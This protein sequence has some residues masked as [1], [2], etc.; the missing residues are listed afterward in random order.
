MAV[1]GTLLAGLS[2]AAPA[3]AGEVG[4]TS[5]AGGVFNVPITSLKEARF[6]RVI[7]QEFDFSCGSAALATLLSYHYDTPINE[8]AVFTDMYNIGDQERIKK[9]GFS[10]LDMKQY[11]A[12]H[13]MRADGFRVD[14]K[15]LVEIGVPAIALIETQGYKHFVVVK[16]VRGDRILVGDPAR[17]TR[18]IP[19]EKF[20]DSLEWHRLRHP[21]QGE[22]RKISFQPGRRLVGRCGCPLRHGDVEARAV[23]LQRAPQGHDDEL[24]L[25]NSMPVDDNNHNALRIRRSLWAGTTAAAAV[26]IGCMGSATAGETLDDSLTGLTPV[27][28]DELK[29]NSGGFSIG[30][31]KVSVG[32]TISTSISGGA[33]G[34]GMTVTT[35]FS[36]ITPGNIQ[37]LGSTITNNVHD[38]LEAAGVSKIGETVA[39]KVKTALGP[40]CWGK[41]TP[42]GRRGR[43]PDIVETPPAGNVV[44]SA[45]AANTPDLGASTPPAADPPVQVATNT[46]DQQSVPDTS[47]TTLR[48]RP[49]RARRRRAQMCRRPAV[50]RRS[51]C[52]RS[53]QE[54]SR[55][56]PTRAAYPR[57]SMF[58]PLW[59]LTRRPDR[60]LLLCRRHR[61]RRRRPRSSPPTTLRRRICRRKCRPLAGRR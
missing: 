25:R 52:R 22:R 11:L 59:S 50:R 35:N 41:A 9:Y 36:V 3:Q 21:R 26:L 23:V 28:T 5:A 19:L 61:R 58:P 18:T 42:R 37:N 40:D 47:A 54:M 56:E 39:A 38:S 34:Q 49:S 60:R 32:F 53:R 43:T 45:D 24:I 12:A 55:A 46:P 1:L 15:R 44:K 30:A 16:G 8:T 17:G 13:N 7:K 57:R 29:A 51:S 48:R 10:L 33:L 20:S 31:V 14:L 2:A 4:F 27:S 6:K